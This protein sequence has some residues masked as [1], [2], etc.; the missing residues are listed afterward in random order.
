MR[1]GLRRKRPRWG[2][3]SKYAGIGSGAVSQNKDKVPRT[4]VT[5]GDVLPG[6]GEREIRKQVMMNFSMDGDLNTL[7]SEW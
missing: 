7:M 5:R 6:Q 2:G 4:D 3:A 1:K